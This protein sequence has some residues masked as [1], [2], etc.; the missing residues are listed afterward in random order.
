MS[1]CAWE[2]PLYQELDSYTTTL[3]ELGNNGPPKPASLSSWKDSPINQHT[4][5]DAITHKLFYFF[6]RKWWRFLFFRVGAVGRRTDLNICLCM[7]SPKGTCLQNISKS[8]YNFKWSSLEDVII[9]IICF[10]LKHESIDK[11][12]FCSIEESGTKVYEQYLE[13]INFDSQR[14]FTDLQKKGS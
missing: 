13:M 9:L 10:F 6:K 4:E 3:M 8:W 11:L 12:H 14:I 7:I 2:L 1:I 5:I